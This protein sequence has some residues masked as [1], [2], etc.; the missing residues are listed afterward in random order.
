MFSSS[1]PD[2][3]PPLNVNAIRQ[4]IFNQALVGYTIW[5]GG[6]G[7]RVLQADSS[8]SNIPITVVMG[9]VGFLPLLLLSRS[10]EGSESAAV[11]NLNLSTN[12]FVLR[13]FGPV[14]RPIVAFIVSAIIA[15]VTGV[16]EETIFRGEALPVIASWYYTNNPLNLGLLSPIQIDPTVVGAVLST[17]LFAV[18]H[19]NPSGVIFGGNEGR[20]EAIQ[21]AIVLFFFQLCTGTTFALLFLASGNLAVPILSHALYDLYT[22]YA[23]HLEV[24][25]QMEYVKKE[26]QTNDISSTLPRSA[27]LAPPSAMDRSVEDRWI[28][29]RGDDF[30][31]GARQT[32]YLMDTNRD[33]VLSRRELRIALYSYGIK[34]TQDQSEAL[35]N[36]AD[37]DGN[38]SI[39]FYEFLA[40]IG[41]EG[42]TT[43]AVK[44]SL[45]GVE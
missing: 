3:P 28:S 11:A 12:M 22:F 41:P 21:D 33:G 10:V 20:G 27:S 45:L 31:T 2:P 43:K 4:V 29:E 9:V 23:T 14:P 36:E 42:S 13:I 7:L 38:G 32:F 18:L 35:V 15:L 26:I 8:L 1:I 5:S 30:V 37:A 40:F 44:R 19:V 6:E 25:S 34:L 16:V 17:I 24:T 39:D